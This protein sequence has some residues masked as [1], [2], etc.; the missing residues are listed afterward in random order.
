MTS[1]IV[2]LFIYLCVFD[3][4]GEN[5]RAYIPMRIRYQSMIC[6]ISFLKNTLVHRGNK[7]QDHAKSIQVKQN[8]RISK[9]NN[10]KKRT[11][12]SRLLSLGV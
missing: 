4:E 7:I 10:I 2:P 6:I 9:Y 3:S 12:P 1:I 11:I 8:I 5:K